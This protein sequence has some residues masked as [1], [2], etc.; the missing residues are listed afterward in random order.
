MKYIFI[1]LLLTGVAP[2]ENPDHNLSNEEIKILTDVHNQ[3]REEVGVPP[4]EWSDTLAQAAAKWAL[5]LKKQN[6]AFKHSRTKY[7]ENL[8]TGTAGF[9]DANYVVNAWGGEKKDYNYQKNDCKPGKMCGHY[10]QIVWKST[11][12][13]G[14]AK[15]ECD[16][17]TTWVCEYYP[18]GNYVGRKPY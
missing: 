17:R 4:L 11:K 8:F 6:C 7:G 12:K 14:C 5:E 15:I 18:A 2:K 16:G 1:L 3:W 13:V 9:Y 10:T